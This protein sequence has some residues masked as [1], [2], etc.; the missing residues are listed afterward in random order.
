MY[1]EQLSQALSVAAAPVHPQS[2]A[3]GTA[4]TGGID[5]SKFR[6]AL[7]VLD[8]GAFGASATVDCKLQES[9]DNSSFADIASAAITQLVAAGGNNRLATLEIRAGQL[10]SGKRYVRA[11]V[12]VGTAATLIQCVALGGEAVDKPGSANDVAA[13]AQRLVV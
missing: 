5:M 2:L 8:V 3:P 4:D 9:A 6:R 10:S 13:V 11:R 7:F 12:T 1:T